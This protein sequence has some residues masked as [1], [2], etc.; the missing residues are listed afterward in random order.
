[1]LGFNEST[2]PDRTEV[3]VE[4][5]VVNLLETDVMACEEAADG[6]ALG[7]PT[8]ATV[9]TDET[10]LEVAWVCDGLEGFGEGPR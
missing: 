7:V 1:M 3:D 6:D 9:G 4:E 2:E 5:A 8:D 10:S